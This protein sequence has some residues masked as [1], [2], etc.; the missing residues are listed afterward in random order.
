MKIILLSGGSGKRLFPMSNDVRSKQFLKLLSDEDGNR[1]SMLQRV[2][3][4]LELAGLADKTYICASSIHSDQIFNQVGDVPLIEEPSSKDTFPAIALS[5]LYLM[6][7]FKCEDETIVVMPIDPYV[8]QSF[9]DNIL[10]L[11]E[12]TTD[13]ISDITLMGVHP[14][15]PSSKF[16]YISIERVANSLYNKV[17]SF[18]EKP[19][20]ARAEQLIGQGALWNCGVFAFQGKFMRRWL[21][22]NEYPTSYD[23]MLEHW[24][25]LPKISFDYEV[26]EKISSAIVIPYRG[27]WKDL[28]TWDVMTSELSHPLI[29][30]GVMVDNLD[31]HVI[32]ELHIPIIVAGTHDLVVIA[33]P[34]GIL[35]SD[36]QHSVGVKEYSKSL[37]LR[38]MYV[39]RRWGD[40]RVLEHRKLSEEQEMQVRYIR[41]DATKSIS[42]HR[43]LNHE[44]TWTVVRGAGLFVCED[45]MV[46]IS[47]GSV[48]KVARGQWHAVKALEELEF[49]EIQR[50][51]G[52]SEE[53]IMRRFLT[54]EEVEQHLGSGSN[55]I[56]NTSMAVF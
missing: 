53:D 42:Y 14:T 8:E 7:R 11:E 41:M 23:A 18:V 6:D 45:E 38:P 26:V 27:T 29:G 16:G 28:G 22:E 1:I 51:S 24:D 5:T 15:T 2:W 19:N 39:E 55:I 9:F 56:R 35:V 49:V 31:T 30:N 13:V 40:Y 46:E 21:A 52:L 4:Q 34:D 50:G 36:K 25:E 43:H 33:T 17:I 32:N 54:W 47:T 20:V 12:Y 44:E 48:I 37:Q 3:R 10:H